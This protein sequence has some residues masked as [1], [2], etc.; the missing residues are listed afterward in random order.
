MAKTD[1]LVLIEERSPDMN[2]MQGKVPQ[3]AV[4]IFIAGAMHRVLSAV[5]SEASFGRRAVSGLR[6]IKIRS[7]T[8]TARRRSGQGEHHSKQIATR[9]HSPTLQAWL[10]SLAHF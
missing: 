8:T 6:Q 5:V 3:K 10:P 1:L 2:V 9:T 7:G 4:G